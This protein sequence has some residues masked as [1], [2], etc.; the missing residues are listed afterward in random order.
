MVF[1]FGKRNLLVPERVPFRLTREMVDPILIEG[2]NGK[3]KSVAVDTLDR[4]RKNSQVLLFSH[5][6][7]ENTTVVR[8]FLKIISSKLPGINWSSACTSA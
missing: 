2:V 5:W 6:L 7:S 8:K 3:F 1:E 4:L